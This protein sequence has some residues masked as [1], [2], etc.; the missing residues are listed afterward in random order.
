MSSYKKI[1][2]FLQILIIIE[3]VNISETSSLYNK[4]KIKETDFASN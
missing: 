4:L 1:N 3:N 2:L